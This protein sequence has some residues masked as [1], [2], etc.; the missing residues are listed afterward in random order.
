MI[1]VGLVGYGYWGPNLARNFHEAPTGSLKAVC[2]LQ[3][4]RLKGLDRKFPSAHLTSNYEE[5]LSRTDIDAVIIATP[6]ASHFPLALAALKAG[7]HVWIEKPIC[8]TSQQ[9]K[10]LI[11]EAD[12]RGLVLHVDHT[13][14]YTG[15]VKFMK[16]QITN[17][18]IG[19]LLYYD[20][21]RVNLGLFQKDVNVLW[22][23]AVHDLAI[24]DHVVP[25]HNPSAISAT[26][27]AHVPGQP[28]NLAY[29]TL[30]F[31]DSRIGH[32]HANW[33]APAKLRRTIFGGDTKMIVYDDLEPSEKIKIYDKGIQVS[34][35]SDIQKMLISYR[36]GDVWCPKVDQSEAL[37]VEARHFLEC[38]E[39]K[40]QSMTDGIA[41]LRIVQLIEAADLSMQKSGAPVEVS[42]I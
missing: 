33:L 7:K 34:E 28:I 24:M 14:V 20:S 23:L 13:F 41:G 18:S 32:I 42:R 16:A 40:K 11:E 25:N 19:S 10:I 29:L 6:T 27:V 37:Q 21:V 36:S 4:H 39:F 22:D 38:I 31:D 15:A 2:D 3:P 17:G 8:S 1:G 35:E 5:M 26:G 12:K 30:L 9:A